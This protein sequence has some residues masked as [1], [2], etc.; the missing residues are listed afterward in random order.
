M[1]IELGYLSLR[2]HPPKRDSQEI[3]CLLGPVAPRVIAGYGGWTNINRP[4]HRSIT[5]WQNSEPLEISVSLLIDNF[6]NG[7]GLTTEHLCTVLERM[8]GYDGQDGDTIP[9]LITWTANAPHDSDDDP[10]LRWV[11]KSL[12]WGDCVRNSEGNR[13]R[14]AADIVLLQFEDDVVLKTGTQKARDR[15][16][17]KSHQRVVRKNPR[18]LV[19]QGETVASI[20][21]DE[22]GRAGRWHEIMKLNTGLIRDPNHPPIG[23]YI[24]LP[25]R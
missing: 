2:T 18:H 22:L 21:K 19:R 7:D 14:Q 9:P 15:K 10:K 11:V 20:A 3:Y 23:R 6:T 8:A 13:T 12:E 24:S 25:F 17:D 4:K 1:P 5:Q 16:K